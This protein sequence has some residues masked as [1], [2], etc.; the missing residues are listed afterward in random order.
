MLLN[1]V[2][3]ENTQPELRFVFNEP[4]QLRE[5][6]GWW[7][8]EDESSA[9]YARFGRTSTTNSSVFLCLFVA[10]IDPT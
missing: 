9:V 4:T 10:L 3:A 1:R 2:T 8:T 6:E 5:W 7:T